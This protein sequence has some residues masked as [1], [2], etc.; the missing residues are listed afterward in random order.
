MILM[1]VLDDHPLSN[2]SLESKWG[3]MLFL[4]ALVHLALF[5]IIFLVPE[6]I[7]TR[8]LEG[9]IYEVNLVELPP[10]A[11][12]QTQ[13]QAPAAKARH[14]TQNITVP[15]KQSPPKRVS[16]PSVKE[17]PV[18]IAKKTIKKKPR[19]AKKPKESPS[20]LIEQA[21]AKIERK[22]ETQKEPGI[23]KKKVDYVDEAVAKIER[24]VK[25]EGGTGQAQGGAPTGVRIQIYKMEV[26]QRIEENWVYPPLLS[27]EK[28]KGLS[29]I[30]V[31]HVKR[32]GSIL[33]S[34][35]VKESSDAIFDQSVLKAIERSNPLP[36][37]PEGYPKIREEFELT[38]SPPETR[39]KAVE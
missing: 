39:G 4:S 32:D 22:V 6:S 28:A 9:V 27:P 24:K 7:P 33:K 14:K 12:L 2:G 26:K 19:Q 31:L 13:R 10:R 8:T 18:V 17:K 16:K 25:T 38:F 30:V 36:P 34:R 11:T 23:Q 37:F 21:V 29:A 3:S 15:R 35:V 20:K 1:E 5:S